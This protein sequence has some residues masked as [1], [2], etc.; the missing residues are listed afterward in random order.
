LLWW[1]PY[2]GWFQDA[3]PDAG[4]S[5]LVPGCRR[6]PGRLLYGW[7]TYLYKKRKRTKTDT[8]VDTERIKEQIKQELVA[9]MQK[10]SI[11]D[12]VFWKEKERRGV[13]IKI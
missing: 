12:G 9:G 3:A 10:Q 8:S 6:Q 1:L 11:V 7:L 2:P 13:A 4:K 5:W